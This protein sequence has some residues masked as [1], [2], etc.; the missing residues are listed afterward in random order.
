MKTKKDIVKILTENKYSFCKKEVRKALKYLKQF[1][2]DDTID[3]ISKDIPSE[4]AYWWGV[5][6]GDRKLMKTRI[7][8]SKWAY[9]WAMR[10]GNIKYMK[11]KMTKSDWICFMENRY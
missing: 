6:V 1:S 5:F 11:K 3:V 10:I 8:K 2:D 7:T 9:L 4:W